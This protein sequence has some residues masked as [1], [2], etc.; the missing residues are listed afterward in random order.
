[1]RWQD[2]PPATQAA[3]WIVASI[4]TGLQGWPCQMPY[5]RAPLLDESWLRTVES[6]LIAWAKRDKARPSSRLHHGTGEGGRSY[7]DE[8]QSFT[9]AQREVIAKTLTAAQWAIVDKAR[10]S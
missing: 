2:V 3:R 4:D 7:I 1:M 6:F 9:A 5:A 10:P 8:S